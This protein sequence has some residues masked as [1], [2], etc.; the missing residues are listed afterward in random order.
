MDH[1]DYRHGGG[2]D[3]RVEEGRGRMQ[4]EMRWNLIGEPT[5]WEFDGEEKVYHA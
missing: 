1:R 3:Y 5:R 4:Q 2:R